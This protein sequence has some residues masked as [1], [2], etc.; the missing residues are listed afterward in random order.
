MNRE[1]PPREDYYRPRR[2]AELRRKAELLERWHQS[3]FQVS[4][5]AGSLF[6][7]TGLVLDIHRHAV[8][9][10]GLVSSVALYL[11]L[12]RLG[13]RTARWRKEAERLEAE[14]QACSEAATAPDA[15]G[16][17]PTEL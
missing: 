17:D 14:H 15:H 6:L 11:C 7:H 8:G 13:T 5:A 12:R 1:L 9:T 16:G 2:A 4:V 10:V 3:R